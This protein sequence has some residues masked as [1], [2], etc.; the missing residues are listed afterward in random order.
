MR[1]SRYR[2]RVAGP[3]DLLKRIH[4]N[5]SG[6]VGMNTL[7]VAAVLAV[8]GVV[9]YKLLNVWALLGIGAAALLAGWWVI[10]H[11]TQIAKQTPH[12]GLMTSEDLRAVLMQEVV[13]KG[14]VE[15]N[16]PPVLEN[17]SYKELPPPPAQPGGQGET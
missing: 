7:V 17:P 2:F 1:D 4:V 3:E 12:I 14:E 13:S 16:R 8:L 6:L 10:R 11:N 15:A 5:P 9:A